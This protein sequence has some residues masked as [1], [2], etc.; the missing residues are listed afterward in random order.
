MNYKTA[1][2]FINNKTETNTAIMSYDKT[3]NRF[4]T[5]KTRNKYSNHELWQ[6]SKQIYHQ[7]NMKQIQQWQKSKQIYHQQNK[8]QIQQWQNNKQIYQ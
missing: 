5:N 7:Q 8:K 4:I 3:A 6:N 2:K 1:K